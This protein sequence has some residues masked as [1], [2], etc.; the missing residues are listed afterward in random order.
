M[1]GILVGGYYNGNKSRVPL[2]FFSKKRRQWFLIIHSGLSTKH[3]LKPITGMVSVGPEILTF[4]SE[5]E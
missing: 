3:D 4:W 5:E 1:D 2:F